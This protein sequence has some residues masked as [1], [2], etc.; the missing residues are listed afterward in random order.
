MTLTCKSEFNKES[1]KF[2]RHLDK[3]GIQAEPSKAEAVL[4]MEAPQ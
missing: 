2:L 4:N 1:V 3:N